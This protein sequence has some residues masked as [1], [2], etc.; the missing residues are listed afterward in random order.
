VLRR[1]KAL[2]AA[3]LLAGSM[4]VGL[5]GTATPAVAGDEPALQ[6]GQVTLYQNP[7]R[8][9]WAQS[10]TYLSC[11]PG[12][13]QPSNL[14]TVGAFDNRPFPGCKVTLHNDLGASFVLCNGSGVVPVQFRQVRVIA[15]TS[16]A[17]P[18]CR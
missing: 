11:S 4:A 8:T 12:L 5:A 10:I 15:I 2:L 7:D 13:W 16:G 17:T 1:T 3:A 14:P 18:P 6:P 9:G